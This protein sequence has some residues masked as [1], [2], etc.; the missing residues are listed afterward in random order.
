MRGEKMIRY[1]LIKL[2]AK[3][4]IK[5]CEKISKKNSPKFI[6]DI[7]NKPVYEMV[8]L[9]TILMEDCALFHQMAKSDVL[10]FEK[11]LLIGKNDNKTIII[12]DLLYKLFIVDF[13]SIYDMKDSDKENNA[14]MRFLEKVEELIQF[15]FILQNGNQI[16]NSENHPC[17]GKNDQQRLRFERKRTEIRRAFGR[18]GNL[19]E[20]IQ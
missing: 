12:N 19:I 2:N 13:K 3:M 1:K 5:F 16:Y 18:R 6:L 14:K 15:G 8:V 10:N 17:D 9:D 4:L 20:M 7:Q 11:L